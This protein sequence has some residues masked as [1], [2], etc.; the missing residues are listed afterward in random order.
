MVP[1]L[2]FSGKLRLWGLTLDWDWDWFFTLFF[3]TL[4][5]GNFPFP[6]GEEGISFGVIRKFWQVL[7]FT[8]RITY[9]GKTCLRGLSAP[10]LKLPKREGNGLIWGKYRETCVG[11]N[12]FIPRHLFP[13]VKNGFFL[14]GAEKGLPELC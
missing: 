5:L 12:L 9:L 10:Y 8:F 11:L 4:P 3:G 6:K 1:F 14:L 2:T 7:K 13:W